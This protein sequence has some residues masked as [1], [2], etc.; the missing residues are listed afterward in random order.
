MK[1]AFTGSGV[2]LIIVAALGWSSLTLS[3]HS[4]A[5]FDKRQEIVIKG[6]VSKVEWRNPHVYFFV[7]ENNDE[8]DTMRYTI[9]SGS[10][11]LLARKGWKRDSLKVGDL[12]SVKIHPLVDGKPGGMLLEITLPDGTVLQG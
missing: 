12:V 3:H 9:E 6:V 1:K 8:G 7:E 10:I 11:N 2:A 4:F 5:M